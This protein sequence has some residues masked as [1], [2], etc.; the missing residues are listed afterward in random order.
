[1]LR[2]KL[3]DT[4]KNYNK[5]QFIQ[6]LSAGVIVGIIAIPLA[7]AFAIASGVTPEKGL[8]TAVIAGFIISFLGG[9]R[10]QIGGP[11]GAFVVIVYGIVEKYGIDG[12]AIATFIAGFFSDNNGIGEI[13]FSNKIYTSPRNSRFY[14]W[15]STNYIFITDKRPLWFK[16]RKSPFRVYR[17]MDRIYFQYTHYKY[18]SINYRYR[19]NTHNSILEKSNRK[20]TR[21]INSYNNIDNCCTGF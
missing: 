13:R 6:D 17:E 14:K 1:M 8:F 16:D 4:L 9:S 3:L 2:P 20:D 11:T 7:I 18:L 5:N 12:L 21:V 19:F 15:N 10:V